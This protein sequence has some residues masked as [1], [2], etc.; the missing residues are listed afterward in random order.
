MLGHLISYR[1]LE[2][3]KEK[4][5]TIQTLNPPTIVRGIRSFLGHACFYHIFIKDLSKIA[6]PP[7]KLLEKD[8]IFNFDEAC[9]KTLKE[10]KNK[11]IEAPIVVVLTWNEPFEIMCN[12]SDFA[13]GVVLGQRRG[14]M[15]RPIYYANKSLNDA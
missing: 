11:L 8:A 7:C 6:K 9:T 10:I 15:F 13:V 4:I 12:A 3:D 14:K 1:G 2:V 5:A